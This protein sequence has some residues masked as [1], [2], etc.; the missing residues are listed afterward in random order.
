M[1]LWER[2]SLHNLSRLNNAFL[3][4]NPNLFA[5][6]EDYLH[7]KYMYCTYIKIQSIAKYYKTQNGK[8]QHKT[9]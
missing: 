8:K 5:S 4:S 6:K 2:A 7:K 3:I 1:L 9:Q